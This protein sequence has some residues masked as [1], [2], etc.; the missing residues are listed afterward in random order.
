MDLRPPPRLAGLEI[1]FVVAAA[2]ETSQAFPTLA[3]I[4]N[5]QHGHLLLG[6][7]FDRRDFASYAAGVSPRG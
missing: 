4:R 6:S 3:G 7:D 5:T 1:A 2:V